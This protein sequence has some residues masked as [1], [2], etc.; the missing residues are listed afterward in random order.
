MKR[1]AYLS[2]LLV[3]LVLLFASLAIAQINT[4]Q[5]NPNQTQTPNSGG[6]T[7]PAQNTTPTQNTTP[8]PSTENT[9]SP[10]PSGQAA[11]VQ[12]KM[13]VSISNYAFNPPQLRVAPGTTV[14]WVNNDTV[15]HTATADNGLFDSGTIQPGGSYSVIFN[16][17]GTVTYHCAIHPEMKG[18]VIVGGGSGGGSTTTGGSS[19]PTQSAT[20]TP[21]QTTGKTTQTAN[22]A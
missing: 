3:I 11:P 15:A 19:N 7:T 18:S 10:N 14:T 17:A 2:L 16:G 8:A 5:Y 12:K 4:N 21:A 1:L 13:T 9:Q 22:G 20:T 6:Q